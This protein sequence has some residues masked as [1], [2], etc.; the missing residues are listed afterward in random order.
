[1]VLE[2]KK[3]NSL[4]SWQTVGTLLSRENT[5]K[6]APNVGSLQTWQESQEISES[7]SLGS[8]TQNRATSVARLLTKE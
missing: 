8:A 4:F 3:I 2:M 7:L 6:E 5:F 1:M